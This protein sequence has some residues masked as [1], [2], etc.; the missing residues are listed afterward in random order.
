[1]R[2]VE[3]FYIDSYFEV[4]L[5]IKHLKRFALRFIFRLRNLLSSSIKYKYYF[6]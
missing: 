5:L 4:Y 1:M 2:V 6:L 3:C